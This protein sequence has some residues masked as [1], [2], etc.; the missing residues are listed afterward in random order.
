[1]SWHAPHRFLPL[2]KKSPWEVE[3][4]LTVGSPAM[5][6]WFLSKRYE[7]QQC[8]L[9]VEAMVAREARNAAAGVSQAKEIGLDKV[10]PR[11][12]F[13]FLKSSASPG[14]LKSMLQVLWGSLATGI[15]RAS[16]KWQC[17]TECSACGGPL[18]TEHLLW[19]CGQQY[20]KELDEIKLAWASGYDAVERGEGHIRSSGVDSKCSINLVGSRQD[21]PSIQTVRLNSS[22]RIS[23]L[24]PVQQSKSPRPGPRP[25]SH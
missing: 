20:P 2:G 23:R 25:R 3:A 18:N 19:G 1:M 14:Q 4:D 13:K 17:E 11:L 24:H 22:I 15:F 7:V 21:A 16:K 6:K 8:N 10:D 5:M 9:F 12:L